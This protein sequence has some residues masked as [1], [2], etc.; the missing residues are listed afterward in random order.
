VLEQFLSLTGEK[1]VK[2]VR[3]ASSPQA[4]WEQSC[5]EG[6]VTRRR[7]C[8]TCKM[9]AENPAAMEMDS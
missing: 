1:W 2:L 5:K 6:V 9:E 4:G 8:K 7:V 3:L